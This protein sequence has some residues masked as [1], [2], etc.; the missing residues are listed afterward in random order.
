MLAPLLLVLLLSTA[1]LGHGLAVSKGFGFVEKSKPGPSLCP[2]GSSLEYDKC[3]QPLHMGDCSGASPE[4]ITRARFSAYAKSRPEFI[5]DSAHPSHKDYARFATASR[6]PRKARRQ[7]EKE[8]V[9]KNSEVYEFLRLDILNSTAVQTDSEEC[10]VTFQILVR[11]KSDGSYLPYQETSVFVRS[12][13][14]PEELKVLKT[15]DYSLRGLDWLYSA[16]HVEPMEEE[17]GQML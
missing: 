8:L 1:H 12:S 14:V 9:S 7:L 3:C 10:R 17:V 5:V 16:S 2:C 6:D 13:S 11:K 4:A 15:R